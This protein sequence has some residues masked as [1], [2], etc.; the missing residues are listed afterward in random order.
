MRYK[1]GVISA[2]PPVT[3][4]STAKGI[5]TLQQQMQARGTNSW[6]LFS[7]FS[8]SPA[9]AFSDSSGSIY[10]TGSGNTP[11]NGDDTVGNTTKYNSSAVQQW[12]RQLGQTTSG[13]SMGLICGKVDSSGNVILSGSY[14]S[15][16]TLGA[17]AKYNTSGTLQWLVG[18]AS[19]YSNGGSITG[20]GTSTISD[21]IYTQSQVTEPGV[22][23][24][25]ITKINSSGALVWQR[26]LF[27]TVSYAGRA[28]AVDNS[29]SIYVP[30][31]AG[32]GFSFTSANLVKYNASGT[33]QWQATLANT[34]S[35]SQSFTDS[36]MLPASTNVYVGGYDN[37]FNIWIVKYNTSG[38][39]QWQ[40]SMNTLSFQT[41]IAVDSSDSVY[42]VANGPSAAV[43][44]KFN[45]SGVL[46]WQ[47][48]LTCTAAPNSGPLGVTPTGITVSGSNFAVALSFSTAANTKLLQGIVLP[49]DGTKTG[50]INASGFTFTYAAS[51]YTQTTTTLSS[52]SSWNTW[53]PVGGF[54]DL[55]SNV[56]SS[57]PTVSIAVPRP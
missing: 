18:Y 36:A 46:Q 25:V 4:E 6:P 15:F 20:I 17:V 41:W 2:T 40:T 10:I 3:S 28:I 13:R 42:A 53:T 32:F 30:C 35:F 37:N 21:N 39:L 5:W 22:N 23:R 48:E 45:S 27:Q 24:V 11:T 44:Y 50:T 54:S 9:Y 51:A 43:I 7:Y 57:T 34:S 52:G 16:Q 12:I 8:N 49:I 14:A 33:L 31:T 55:T 19:E 26:G 1:G 29:E 56:V 38:T 47:R